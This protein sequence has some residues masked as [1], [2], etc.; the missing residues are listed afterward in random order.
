MWQWHWSKYK[1]IYCFLR[2]WVE[3]FTSE[4]FWSISRKWKPKP[5]S[6]IIW[7]CGRN[8]N[9]TQRLACSPCVCSVEI[10]RKQIGNNAG[11]G[12]TVAPPPS[13]VQL[14]F[15]RNSL[16]LILRIVQSAS[17]LQSR[18]DTVCK[19]EQWLSCS[20][21]RCVACWRLRRRWTRMKCPSPH[22]LFGLRG[23]SHCWRSGK[24]F[25]ITLICRHGRSSGYLHVKGSYD[26]VE[27]LLVLVPSACNVHWG[28]RVF[29]RW[30]SVPGA[31]VSNM[32]V[33]FEK[34]TE[35]LFLCSSW[36]SVMQV[37][38][39]QLTFFRPWWGDPSSGRQQ[40]LET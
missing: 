14:V 16:W 8:T 10:S 4:H 9:Q 20:L 32:Q 22:L 39:S 18:K 15:G 29:Q 35:V 31:A 34:F 25:C 5:C 7:T 30:C 19:R 28:R 2:W 17:L 24:A 12:F 26:S 37:P 13:R 23:G 33:V 6:L 11:E 27:I 38:I 3:C 21:E 1:L 36:R 40:K